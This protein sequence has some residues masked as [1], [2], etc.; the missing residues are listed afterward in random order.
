MYSFGGHIGDIGK[1]LKKHVLEE[2]MQFGRLAIYSCMRVPMF[3]IC[4]SLRS[5]LDSGSIMKY[6]KNY[7]AAKWDPEV[8]ELLQD[9]IND[10]N[11]INTRLLNII[12]IIL[13]NEKGGDH[14]N[15]LQ[16]TKAHWLSCGKMLKEVIK[17]KDELCLF[18]FTK[19]QVF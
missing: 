10:V 4:L 12:F 7:L 18:A 15:L 1:D 17:L 9:V 2:I 13:C 11:F 3:L 16:H 6:T 19:S 8:H 5:L 14:A